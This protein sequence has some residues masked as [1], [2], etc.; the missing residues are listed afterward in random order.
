MLPFVIGTLV[1]MIVALQWNFSVVEMM[2]TSPK[3]GLFVHTWHDLNPP[4][5]RNVMGSTNVPGWNWWG[6]PAFA[7]GDLAQYSWDN[8]RMIK[9]HI[10]NFVKL[11]VD[12]VFLDFTNGNQPQIM[13]GAHA[14][15]KNLAA[16]KDGPKVA[17]WIEKPEYAKLFLTEFYERY[18]DIMFH[19]RGKPLLLIAGRSDGWV[20]AAGKVKP[21]PKGLPEFTVRWC[22]GLLNE[23]SG[24][25]WTFKETSPPKPYVH[26]GVVEQIGMAFATQETYMT[27]KQGRK[28]R[29]NGKFFE[30]QIQNVRTHRPEIITITGYNEWMAINQGTSTNPVF[31][32]LASP[33][34]SHDIEPMHGGHGAKYFDQAK[35]FVRTIKQVNSGITSNDS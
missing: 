33:D 5:V 3:I 32:D 26:K 11:G 20:P 4:P 35:D 24:T 19:H 13:R 27:T 21:L 9:Y 12:F 31:V 10:D 14:L 30:S 25:M 22:W 18:P 8:A 7:G 29:D 15:C 16:R 34:C 17:F 2:T 1:I 6:K 28:C 23:G